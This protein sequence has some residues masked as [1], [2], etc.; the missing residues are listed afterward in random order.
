MKAKGANTFAM[1]QRVSQALRQFADDGT[2]AAF[3]SEIFG[4]N[5]A[6]VV[7]LMQ[8]F[9][10]LTGSANKYADSV[11]K[12]IN[13]ATKMN[14]KLNELS[15]SWHTLMEDAATP[16]NFVVNIVINGLDLLKLIPE[17]LNKLGN[18][19]YD[20][21]VKLRNLSVF[22]VHPFAG[23]LA[24]NSK[25][26]GYDERHNA[27]PST[28]LPDVDVGAKKPHMQPFSAPNAR[29]GNAHPMF[30]EQEDD[31]ERLR[32]K[33]AQLRA[34]HQLFS[35]QQDAGFEHERIQSQLRQ[36]D[37]DISPVHRAQSNYTAAKASG[38]AKIADVQKLASETA[39]I[40]AA[41][42]SDAKKQYERRCH[43][44]RKCDEEQ[45]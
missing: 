30:K 2:K 31:I 18:Y 16:L 32:Q 24:L 33:L 22:G 25:P 26:P 23:G 36:G 4:R 34:E 28:T 27:V 20:E 44:I 10:G 38:A 42:A 6:A 11:D 9:D 3:L 39:T 45:D 29:G 43:G 35:E 14:D 17:E 13:T 15:L 7:K 8:D 37:K 1:L 12:N 5:D 40:Y 41:M 19:M 21:G